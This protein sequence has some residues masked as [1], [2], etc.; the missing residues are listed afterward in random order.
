MPDGTYV[1]SHSSLAEQARD[2]L[3]GKGIVNP[4]IQVEDPSAFD[5]IK[6]PAERRQA[7]AGVMAQARLAHNSTLE[8]NSELTRKEDEANMRKTA[9]SVKM[10]ISD[11][12]VSDKVISG[13][14][15]ALLTD[16]K[17]RAVAEVAKTTIAMKEAH[18]ETLSKELEKEKRE[19]AAL[20]ERIKMMGG[21]TDSTKRRKHSGSSSSSEPRDFMAIFNTIYGGGSAPSSSSSSSSSSSPVPKKQA[22]PEKRLEHGRGA[23]RSTRDESSS[24]Q[25]ELH[26]KYRW[27][28]VSLF[29][30]P[31][32]ESMKIVSHSS[33]GSQIITFPDQERVVKHS[34]S[35]MPTITLSPET[36]IPPLKISSEILASIMKGE[37]DIGDGVRPDLL[38]NSMFG[39]HPQGFVAL[40]HSIE[41]GAIETNG[42]LNIRGWAQ[43]EKKH[44]TNGLKFIPRIPRDAPAHL[45][46]DRKKFD[47]ENLPVR[48][49]AAT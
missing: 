47:L 17:A 7:I 35:G 13:L 49:F 8:A 32:K 38:S 14:G 12:N 21:S 44:S 15:N 5:D 40:M 16:P 43:K 10:L 18:A 28:G 34:S 46:V 45:R 42:D 48:F 19:N 27:N 37:R 33:T 29:P 36:N 39:I 4:K 30:D 11:G 2:F 31:S 1:V 22:E 25:E 26:T 6:D 24:H 20:L 41:T 23:K 3:T 9:E